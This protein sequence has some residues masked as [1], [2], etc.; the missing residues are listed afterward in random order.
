MVALTCCCSSHL[1]MVGPNL[2]VGAAAEAE[3]G[4]DAVLGLEPTQLNVR[5]AMKQGS[6]EVES[7]QEMWGETGRQHSRQEVLTEQAE[8]TAG[9][10]N[11]LS[12]VAD[13]PES[14]ADIFALRHD[15]QVDE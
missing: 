1:G 8:N 13:T 9:L 2:L 15:T 4:R 7:R 6:R 14:R 11:A 10:K 3:L 5:Q 12:K